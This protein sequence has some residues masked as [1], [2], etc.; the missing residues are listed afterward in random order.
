MVQQDNPTYRFADFELQPDERRLL[1]GCDVI[2]LTPKVFEILRLLVERAGHAVSKDEIMAAIWPARF[3]AESNLTKHIWTLRQALGENEEGGRFI[4]TVP[5][6]GYRFVAPVTR[7]G[8]TAEAS[9]SSASGFKEPLPVLRRERRTFFRIGALLAAL[10]FAAGALAAWWVWS[11][12]EPVFPWSRRAPGTAIAVFDFN[13]LSHDPAYA[14]IGPA[15]AEMLGTEIAAGGQLHLLPGELVRQIRGGTPDAGA[16]GFSPDTLTT[17]HRQLVVDYTVTGSY[18]AFDRPGKQYVR[19]DLTV[20]DAR[21]GATVATFSRSGSPQDLPSLVA[22]AGADLRKHLHVVPQSAGEMR[23]TA[24]ARPPSADVMRRLGFALDALHRYDSARARDELLQAVADAP[25]YAPSYVYLAKAWSALGYDQKA[26]ATS[27]QA[28][29][30]SAGLPQAMRLNIE[31]QSYEAQF[32]WPKAIAALRELAALQPDEAETQFELAHVLLSAG[33]VT[34][35]QDVLGALRKRGE[36]TTSDPRLE[37]ADADVAAAKDDS[38]TRIEHARRAL[39][40]AEARDATGLKADAELVLGVALPAAEANIAEAM[41]ERA[42]ADYRRVSNPRGEAAVHLNVGNLLSYTQPKRARVEYEESL[43]QFQ[44]MGDQ[45]GVASAYSDLANI[46]WASGDRDGAEAAVRNVLRIRRETSSLVGQA[47][48]LTAL[49]IAEADER[50][51]DESISNFREA[52]ALDASAGAHSH[53]GFT[54][55]SLA[56]ILRLRGD[57]TQAQL[58]C[59]EA[60]GEYARVK[61]TANSINADYEC[62]LISRDRGDLASVTPVLERARNM[63]ALSGDTE[64]LVNANLTEGEITMEQGHWLEA[65]KLLDAAQKQAAAADL[66]TGEAVAVS[67]LAKCYSALGK[68]AERDTAISHAANLRSAMTERQEVMQVDVAL[69]ELRGETGNSAEAISKL[70]SMATDARARRWPGWALEAELAELHVL[71]RTGQRASALALRARVAGEA[72]R[73]GF[74]W[75]LERVAR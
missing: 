61:D 55:S 13:N 33:K 68:A 6:L 56:D 32:N 26:L 1:H 64:S 22:V 69:T 16:G 38:K 8:P 71:K 15:F 30:H 5:K 7:A 31:A 52:A 28:A 70:Q 14:W 49:A 42:L 10:V 3:V 12:S 41:L 20:Q 25:D 37:L 21:S 66:K 50:A 11:G 34:D 53:R 51:S 35:A 59:I 36:P 40:L 74:G 72:R 9:R 4:E 19:L 62:A 58:A 63:A 73:Q 2:P 44:N 48:A 75:V 45:N 39:Q 60:R 54:L 18:L 47:W 46:L 57:F 23:Q 43:A 67:L 65:A 17:L 27:E 24:N 29:A